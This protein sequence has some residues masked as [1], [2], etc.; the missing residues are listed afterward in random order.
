MP[1]ITGHLQS[2]GA[3][4]E[5]FSFSKGIPRLINLAAD[6]T[7]LAGYVK[8]TK[9]LTREMAGRGIRSLSGRPDHQERLIPRNP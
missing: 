3:V 4:R 2:M 8:G 9:T 1:R 6:R 7:L 5:I